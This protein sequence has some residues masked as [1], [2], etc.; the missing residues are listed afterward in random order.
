MLNCYLP[1]YIHKRK[2]NKSSDDFKKKQA[3]KNSL[4]TNTGASMKTANTIYIYIFL[5]S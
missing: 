4:H 3:H 1:Y 5:Y 2:T